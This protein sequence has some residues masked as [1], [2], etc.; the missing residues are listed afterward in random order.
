MYTEINEKFISEFTD[1]FVSF[2]D[3][4][5]N[6]LIMSERS[7]F[8]HVYRY[9]IEGGF[10]NAVTSGEWEVDEIL[11]VDEEADVLYYTSTEVSPL[12]RHIYK[13]SFDGTGK[14]RIQP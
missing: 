13:I 6:V 9:N 3:S 2:T 14:E 8:M 10:L 5:R 12:E 7:G 11:G 4:G 1:D